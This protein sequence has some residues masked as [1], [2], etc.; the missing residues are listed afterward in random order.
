MKGLDAEVPEPMVVV[1]EY[2]YFTRE[3]HPLSECMSVDGI[4]LASYN[5]IGKQLAHTYMAVQ[6]DH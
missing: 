6:C 5:C 3:L 2:V 4:S 1:G